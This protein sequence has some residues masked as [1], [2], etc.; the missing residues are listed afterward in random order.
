MSRPV[1]AV[2]ALCRKE[3][4]DRLG[5]TAVKEAEAEMSWRGGMVEEAVS[6]ASKSVGGNNVYMF[7]VFILIHLELSFSSASMREEHSV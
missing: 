3:R 7:G 5:E 2:M 6:S 1:P 4:R